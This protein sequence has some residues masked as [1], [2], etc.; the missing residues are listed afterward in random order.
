M[1]NVALITGAS[2]GIGKELATIHA[3]NGNDI[4]AV[5]SNLSRLQ[6]LRDELDAEY[7]VNVIIIA[8]DLTEEGAA[9]AVFGAVQE[10]GIEIEY[11]MNNAG[12]GGHGKFHERDWEQDARMIQLNVVVLTELT[13][14]FLPIF[15]ERKHGRILNTSSTASL[16]PGPLQAVYYA[17]KAYV[18]SFSNALAGELHDSPVTVTNLMPGA[19]NTGFV[20]SSG[21]EGTDMFSDLGSP[22]RVAKAGYDAMMRGEIDV[23]SGLRLSHR[24]TLSLVPF[25]P[26]RLVLSQ[27]REGQEVKAR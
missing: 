22:V 1:K 14:L 17:T 16:V 21:L 20:T 7:G 11:L 13:R 5:A 26:K 23:V 12:F 10:A 15:V 4:V 18:T 9:K 3:E 25:L 2:S 8:Q 27:V 19:T 6:D 24:I